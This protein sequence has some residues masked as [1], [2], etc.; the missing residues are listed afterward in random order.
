MPVC[1]VIKMQTVDNSQ[2]FGTLL[3][4]SLKAFDCLR[5]GF[6]IAKS[7][8]LAFSLKGFESD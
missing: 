2:V 7:N 6:L 1:N 3:T 4:D 8:A 5:D